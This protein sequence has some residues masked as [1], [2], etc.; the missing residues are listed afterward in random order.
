VLL[1]L[2]DELV[3]GGWSCGP[4]GVERIDDLAEVEIQGAPLPR[5]L[6]DRVVALIPAL[7]SRPGCD[8]SGSAFLKRGLAMIPE[9]TT[10]KCCS[11][12]SGEDIKDIP[13]FKATFGHSPFWA[14]PLRMFDD[15]RL[16]L[17]N[18]FVRAHSNEAWVAKLFGGGELHAT[19]L[20]DLANQ[21]SSLSFRP[22]FN[23]F[24]VGEASAHIAD[25]RGD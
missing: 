4:V 13:W 10:I 17:P 15:S 11:S 14:L 22:Q 7:S 18:E 12:Q 3:T 8:S 25:R 24:L 19:D 16:A 6:A 23:S 1:S 21:R 5:G 2:R 9:R 20:D